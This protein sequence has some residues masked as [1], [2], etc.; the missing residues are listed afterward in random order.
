MFKTKFVSVGEMDLEILSELHSRHPG[1]SVD[2][3]V[4]EPSAQQLHDYKGIGTGLI[5][6]G[7]FPKA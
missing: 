6:A 2:N 1:A 4:L 3:E 7:R 5:C